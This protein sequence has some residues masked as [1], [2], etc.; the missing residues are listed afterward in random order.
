MRVAHQYG[1]PEPLWTA[2]LGMGMLLSMVYS[3]AALI[4]HWPSGFVVSYSQTPFRILLA[5]PSF[6]PLLWLLHGLP[7]P[8]AMAGVVL[9]EGIKILLLE[10]SRRHPRATRDRRP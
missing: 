5:M 1:G 9:S 3:S 2:L 8:L 7:L 10:Y 6:L 4:R